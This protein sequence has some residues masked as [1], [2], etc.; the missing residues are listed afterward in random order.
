MIYWSR[1]FYAQRRT[2]RNTRRAAPPPTAREEN[3]PQLCAHLF[4]VR[5]STEQRSLFNRSPPIGPQVLEVVL[6]LLLTALL[7]PARSEV[8]MCHWALFSR[9][10]E[11]NI[12]SRQHTVLQ[13]ACDPKGERKSRLVLLVIIVIRIIDARVSIG[14]QR[15]CFAPDVGDVH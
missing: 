2:C 4:V 12:N 14:L 5:E 13:E 15:C 11:L 7:C 3:N 1:H 8:F 6:L 9:A 10:G